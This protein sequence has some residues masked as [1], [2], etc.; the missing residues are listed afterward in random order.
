MTPEYICK[1]L[2]LNIDDI[3][4]IYPYGSRVYGTERPDSDY[5]FIIVFKS[6]MLPSGAFKDNAI[7][8]SD[9]TIQGTCYGRGGFIDAINNYQLPAWEA[10]SSEPVKFKFPFNVSKYYE[11]DMIKKVITQASNSFFMADSLWTIKDSPGMMDRMKKGV[12][13]SLRIVKFGLQ[14]KEHKRIVDFTDANQDLHNIMNDDRFTPH[15]II[16]YRDR[17][18]NQLKNN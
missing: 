15:S 1:E 16:P 6:S 5:D 7:S 4:N 17:L 11:K 3:F 10:L 2:G 12:W 14:I 18:I 13:H 9:R 8:N